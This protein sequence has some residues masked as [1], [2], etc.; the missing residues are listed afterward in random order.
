MK[1]SHLRTPRQ[2]RD[3]WDDTRLDT[4]KENTLLDWFAVFCIGVAIG[5]IFGLGVR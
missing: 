4:E 5:L 1:P 2:R 3:C